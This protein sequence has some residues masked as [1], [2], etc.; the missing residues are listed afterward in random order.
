MRPE[1][2]IMEQKFTEEV[3]LFCSRLELEEFIQRFQKAF[4]RK[5]SNLANLPTASVEVETDNYDLSSEAAGKYASKDRQ[6]YVVKQEFSYTVHEKDGCPCEEDLDLL[7]DR[8][9]EVVKESVEDIP[10]FSFLGFDSG[11]PR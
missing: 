1:Q 11:H 5:F 4:I 6:N 8:V 10:F 9:F 7:S 3:H 2:K